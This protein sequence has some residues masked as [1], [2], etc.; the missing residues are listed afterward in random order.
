MYM[1]QD[2]GSIYSIYWYIHMY[3]G[4]CRCYIYYIIGF[5]CCLHLL[6]LLWVFFVVLCDNIRLSE[7]FGV[8][9][10]TD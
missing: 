8:T 1:Y 6:Y 2:I 7:F 9:N 5:D 10:V 4:F 3:L